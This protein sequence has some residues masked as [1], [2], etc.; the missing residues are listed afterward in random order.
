LAVIAIGVIVATM[1]ARSRDIWAPAAGVM[2]LGAIALAISLVGDLP[3]AT[4]S[5]LT[6]KLESANASP[7]AGFWVQLAGAI[8]LLGSG[9]TMTYLLRHRAL[10]GKRA[11]DMG[12]RSD[13]SR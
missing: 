2:A 11:P 3:D 13:D 5:G 8:A 4:S 7:A 9:A 6:T 12:S 1:V 10:P